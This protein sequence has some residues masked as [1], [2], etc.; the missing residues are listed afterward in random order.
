MVPQPMTEP[1]PVKMPLEVIPIIPPNA[2]GYTVPIPSSVPYPDPEP[3]PIIVAEPLKLPLV[4]IIVPQPMT[5][6]AEPMIEV[7][8]REQNARLSINLPE[9]VPDETTPNPPAT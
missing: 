2:A 4:A 1:L 8:T 7:N 3:Q 5:L 6:V 9:S